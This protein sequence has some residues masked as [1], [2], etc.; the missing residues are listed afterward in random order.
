MRFLTNLNQL[1]SLRY[2]KK[3]VLPGV[4]IPGPNKPKNIDSFLFPGFHHVAALQHEGL[5]IWDALQDTRYISNL[6]IALGTADGPGLAY[7]NGLVGH[8]GRNGCRLYCGMPGCLKTNGHTYYPVLSRPFN[9]NIPG[10]DHDDIDPETYG[11][12]CS[13]GTYFAKLTYLLLSPNETQYKK[14]RLKTGISK[15]SIFLGFRDGCTL[16]VPKCF[17]SDIMHLLSLNIPDL[18]IP[19]WRGT[20]ECDPGDD[21]ATWVWAALSDPAV[22]KAHGEAVANATVDIPGIYGRPPRNPAEKIQSGYKAWEF[23]LYLYGLGPGLLHGILP[24][25]YWCHYCK[26]V[27]AVRIISQHSITREE[28]RSAHG[29]FIEFVK[30]FETHYSQRKK[31]R[32]HFVRQ[33]IHALTHYGQEVQTKGPL[34]CASQWTMERTIGNLTEEIRQHSNPYANLTQRAVWR[35]QVNALKAMIPSLDPDHNKPTNPRWSLDIGSGYLLLPRHERSRH[36][37]TP[38]ENTVILSWLEANAPR[39]PEHGFISHSSGLLKVRRW[40]RLQLPNGQKV[41]SLWCGRETKANARKSR[42][43]KVS[44]LILFFVVHHNCLVYILSAH[45]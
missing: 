19:L 10:S 7:L 42:N 45:H 14:R 13:P 30:D 22:W 2:K 4:V 29:L 23:H 15:P 32:I 41:R 1:Y 44:L 43:V 8:H 21:K 31:E 9:Y 24:E 5:P 27:R 11:G 12:C 25:A 17:G 3:Y 16:G 38:A 34:I 37:V 18:L 39:S 36:E 35:A 28:L 6:F 40:A 33:S 26:L 20:F